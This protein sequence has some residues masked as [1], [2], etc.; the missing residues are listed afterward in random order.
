MR[1]L[2]ALSVLLFCANAAMGANFYHIGN[3]L[4]VD[5]LGYEYLASQ[6]GLPLSY[7]QHIRGGKSLPAIAAE[8]F[9]NDVSDP[10]YSNFGTALDGFTWDSVTLQPFYNG[11]LGQ[12]EATINAMIT[13]T[14]NRPANA[15]TA[16]YIYAAWPGRPNTGTFADNWLLPSTN[17][18]T[19]GTI[20]SRDYFDKLITRVRA[21]QPAG[22]EPIR[23]IPVGEVVYELEKKILNDEIPGLTS[24]AD[25]YRDD[26]HFNNVG[27]Y[28]AAETFFAVLFKTDPR[29]ASLPALGF[30]AIEDW[31]EI[32]PAMASSIQDTVWDVVTHNSFTAV[33]EPAS[34]GLLAAAGAILIGRRRRR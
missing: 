26:V 12:D 9:V 15:N 28:I 7:G 16:F 24:A 8:P 33:P 20:L 2:I 27:H 29:G 14:R 23:M 6:A 17:D 4:T 10:T 13:Q 21:S 34:L 30:G 1:Q 19:Q 11:T 31:P 22:S 3:S 18:D 32:T 5:A 25:L